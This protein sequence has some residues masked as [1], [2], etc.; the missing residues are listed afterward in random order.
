[1]LKAYKKNVTSDLQKAV[2]QKERIYQKYCCL[3]AVC[4]SVN[5]TD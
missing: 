2:A 4:D 1:M 3:K 5:T